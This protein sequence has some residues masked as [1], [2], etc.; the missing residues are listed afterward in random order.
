MGSLLPRRTG[1]SGDGYLADE[2]AKVLSYRYEIY[3][4][5]LACVG[6]VFLAFTGEARS[7]MAVRSRT[8][9]RPDETHGTETLTAS[10]A[11]TP[12]TGR[13][14]G[15]NPTNRPGAAGG[16]VRSD[17]GPVPCGLTG[18]GRA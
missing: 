7:Q 17:G 11:K 1:Q 16:P 12:H 15:Q 9:D 6:R 4:V 5:R 8:P 10:A 2:L 14:H 3:V 18:C 13:A